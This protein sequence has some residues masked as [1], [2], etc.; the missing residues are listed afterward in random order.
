M[1][2]QINPSHPEHTAPSAA[3]QEDVPTTTPS[4]AGALLPFFG[5]VPALTVVALQFAAGSFNPIEF[6]ID[7]YGSG[8]SHR[9]EQK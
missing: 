3:H 4:T 9:P 2:S 5:A 7:S 1:D 6:L 8:G